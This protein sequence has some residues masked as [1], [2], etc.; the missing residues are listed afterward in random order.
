M[1]RLLACLLP[2]LA[3]IG[4]CDPK[5]ASEAESRKD[6]PWLAS[7]PTGESVAALGRLADADPRAVA[8][9]EAR[10][11]R[12]VNV[13]I[14]AWA[15][16]TR[17]APWG[18][19][20]LKD[21]LGDPSR[22]E[23]AASAMPRRDA[24]LSPFIAELDGAVLRLASGT[25]GSV[26]AGVLASIGPPAH[27]AIE[28][29]LLDG[30]TR[31][32]MCDAIRLP[33]ASGDAKS[34]LLA[35]SPAARDSA[36]CVSAVVELAAAEDVV[37][38]WL[39]TSAE[40]GLIG[41]AATGALPCARLAVVWKQALA[42]RPPEA[43]PAL[44]VPLRRSLVRCATPIDP[45]LADLLVS[46]PRARATILQG[47]DPFGTELSSMKATCAAL[48]AGAARSESS[49]LRARAAD[50]LDRGCAFAN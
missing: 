13:Y 47:I 37:L 25:R 15:A 43:Q 49:L 39:A 3:T 7:N 30:K 33:E 46:E 11:A 36:S 9:L 42:S 28:R 20:L 22:A 31:S 29:R 44:S 8:A 38:D 10:A 41:A 5:S 50:A 34:V 32:A 27:D 17:S 4:A 24:R 35:V 21:A 1:R 40:P 45:V 6:V 14:A 18:T 26:V 23:L 19:T 16:V 12:D 2:L 48:K